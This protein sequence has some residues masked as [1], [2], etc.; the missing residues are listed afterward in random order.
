MSDMAALD[1][2]I[3]A[4]YLLN[5]IP[6]HSERARNLLKSAARGDASLFLP[7]SVFVEIAHLMT[8]RRSIPRQRVATALMQLLRLEGIHI[9]ERNAVADALTFWETIGGVSFV[10][11]YHLALTRSLGMSRIYT[12]DRKM[13]RFPRVERIEP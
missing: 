10:D 3:I 6:D 2:N 9:Q 7:A 4:R 13:N 8:R 11:C 5:D 1:T 12:F